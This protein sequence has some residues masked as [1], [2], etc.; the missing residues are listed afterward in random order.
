MGK[1]KLSACLTL[2]VATVLFS[3]HV[4]CKPFLGG[5]LGGLFG[6]GKKGGS[7]G[8]GG[9]RSGGHMRM[10]APMSSYGAPMQSAGPHPMP[11]G[12]YGGMKQGG[13]GIGDIFGMIPQL[14]G[15]KVGLVSGLVGKKVGLVTGLAG[16][17]IG[18][19]TG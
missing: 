11:M 7:G 8:Y 19:V 17:K 1:M 6:G 4:D 2:F 12:G 9:M 14:I 3:S 13:G 5:L 15:K 16:K 10:A 18:L